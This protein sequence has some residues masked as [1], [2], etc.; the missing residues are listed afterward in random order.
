MLQPRKGKVKRRVSASE[1]KARPKIPMASDAAPDGVP[2][3]LIVAID[4]G[5]INLSL[6]ALRCAHW[7]EVSER[8]PRLEDARKRLAQAEFER[9]EVVSLGLPRGASFAARSEAVAAFVQERRDVFASARAVV[10]EHQMQATMRT[11]A[12][13]LFTAVRMI[14][15]DCLLFSQQS[16]DKLRW[17]DLGEPARGSVDLS[18]YSK[19]KRVSVSVAYYLL[20]MDAPQPQAKR[21]RT[22]AVPRLDS[23]DTAASG[24]LPAMRAILSSSQKKDDLADA[25]LHLCAFD[26]VHN[27]TAPPSRRRKASVRSSCSPPATQAQS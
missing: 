5:L 13:A 26:C 2:K 9:W 21:R 4:V 11:V 8:P 24:P 25:L 20:A 23:Y 14:S 17:K 18:T 6:C 27:P 16:K 15:Q 3:S 19:R 10:I 7:A 1:R 12:A 22:G